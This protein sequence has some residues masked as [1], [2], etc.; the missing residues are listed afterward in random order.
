M[1]VILNVVESISVTLFSKSAALIIIE[2]SSLI[3]NEVVANT[4]ASLTAA[5]LIEPLD[6]VSAVPSETVKA[7][8]TLHSIIIKAADLLNNVTDIDSTTL[9]ITN[10]TTADRH[11]TITAHGTNGDEWLYTPAENYSGDAKLTISVNDGTITADFE[12]AVTITPVADAPELT[13]S[14]GRVLVDE[15]NENNI[16]NSVLS[17]WK[18][19]NKD[20]Q[21]EVNPDTHLV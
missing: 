15:F 9:S 18:T 7:K 11:G 16:S 1:F 14:L 4:G 8:G 6:L 12:S 21:I 13:V 2:L 3:V 20:G 19:D 5:R 10:I 17:G